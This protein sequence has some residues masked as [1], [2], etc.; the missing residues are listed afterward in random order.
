MGDNNSLEYPPPDPETS[1]IVLQ[2]TIFNVTIIA[3]QEVNLLSRARNPQHVAKK[4]RYVA[5]DLIRQQGYRVSHGV[6][7]KLWVTDGQRVAQVEAKLARHGRDQR[8]RDRYQAAIYNHAADVLIFIARN[9]EGDYP[10]II[11]MSDITPRRNISIWSRN[12]EDYSGQWAPY[13]ND[14]ER[15]EQAIQAAVTQDDWQLSL[16]Q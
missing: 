7:G 3:P 15:L 8:G 5:A 6:S 9:E 12:P 16:F 10:F 1:P 4:A 2:P 13:L 11:P 14:W